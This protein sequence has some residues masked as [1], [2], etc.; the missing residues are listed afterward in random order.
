MLEIKT[1]ILSLDRNDL[2]ERY[3][4]TNFIN[5]GINLFDIPITLYDSCDIV[6]FNDK[7]EIGD[8]K[9]TKVLKNKIF[10]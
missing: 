1:K 2:K 10:N 7:H 3:K 8:K 4:E 5:I 6:I 9:S